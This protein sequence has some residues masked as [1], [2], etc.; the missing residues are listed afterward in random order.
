M[1]SC[2][3]S[4]IFNGPLRERNV[5]DKRSLAILAQ[6]VRCTEPVLRFGSVREPGKTDQY[7]I[8]P[9]ND[10]RERSQF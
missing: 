9:Q 3:Q 10:V 4:Q 8:L 5:L 2:L 1:G 7:I 6:Y